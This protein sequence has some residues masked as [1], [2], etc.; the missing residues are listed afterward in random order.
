MISGEW[1]Y[2][3]VLN[4]CPITKAMQEDIS[5]VWNARTMLQSGFE[6]CT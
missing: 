1:K 2:L 4:A 6:I 3:S 5:C